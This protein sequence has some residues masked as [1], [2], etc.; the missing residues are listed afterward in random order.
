[1]ILVSNSLCAHKKGLVR[2]L[3]YKNIKKTFIIFIKETW[4]PVEYKSFP[5]YIFENREEESVTM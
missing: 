1:M 4:F 2:T 5:G 3:H